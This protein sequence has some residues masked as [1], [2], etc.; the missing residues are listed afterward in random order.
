MTGWRVRERRVRQH[1]TGYS[2]YLAHE[3]CQVKG[4]VLYCSVFCK[5]GTDFEVRRKTGS[6]S[7]K[8][9]KI[10]TMS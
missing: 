8:S 10:F 7:Q 2:A 9:W 6:D 3:W 4:A 5:T 1:V